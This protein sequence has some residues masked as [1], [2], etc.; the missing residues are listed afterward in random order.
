VAVFAADHIYR[1]DV[2]QMA[3]FHE[4]CGADVTVAAARV[5]VDLASSFGVLE[6]G[7]TARYRTFRKSPQRPA[8]CRAMR[9][10]PMSRWATTC[11]TRTC[12]WGCCWRRRAAAATDFGHDILPRLPGRQ[13]IYAYDFARN[14]IPG[15]LSHEERSYWR[16][17]G[18][19][20]PCGRPRTTSPGPN[21]FQPVERAMA[22]IRRAQAAWSRLAARRPKGPDTRIAPEPRRPQPHASAA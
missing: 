9:R 5:P 13:R 20:E 10:S 1:M 18:T 22:H 3:W 17:V 12:S 11:S 2:G 4:A 21:P 15:L 7:P 16:D 14:Y 19:L 8:P 6:S